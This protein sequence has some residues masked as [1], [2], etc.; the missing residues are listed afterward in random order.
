MYLEENLMLEHGGR[1]LRICRKRSEK[2]IID[3]EAVDENSGS[4]YVLRTLN[5]DTLSTS[6]R[7][8]WQNRL[9]REVT[10]LKKCESP[11]I[12]E[13][14]DI[15]FCNIKGTMTS[16]EILCILMEYISGDSLYK[17]VVSS[18]DRKIHK[19]AAVAYIKQIASALKLMHSEG[20]VHLNVRPQNI[21]I[22]STNNQAVLTNFSVARNFSNKLTF[23]ALAEQDTGFT[24]PEL[25]PECYISGENPDPRSDIY[26]LGATL[27]FLITGETTSLQEHQSRQNHT[28]AY[29]KK[30][31]NSRLA[32]AIDQA[33][34]H[35][36]DHRPQSIEKWMTS[37]PLTLPTMIK[38]R[39]ELI[40]GTIAL[41]TI[42]LTLI[43]HWSN[44][45]TLFEF[46]CPPEGDSQESVSE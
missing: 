15:F 34:Q 14:V 25:S 45:C 43:G 10:V 8:A 2:F 17:L 35:N 7:I 36:I 39:K 23:S 29:E 11:H 38:E 3:Y 18:K 9:L 22:R 20:F 42:L 44:F 31:V 28:F 37:L 24:P 4:S 40:G 5:P 27:Y 46:T 6:D 21:K 30:I 32:K 12:V 19:R 26:A 33:M 13:I 41:L 1:R 16:G